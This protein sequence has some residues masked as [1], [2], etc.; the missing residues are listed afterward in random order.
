MG[1]GRAVQS[2]YCGKNKTR[3]RDGKNPKEFW[4]RQ[5]VFP[6]KILYKKRNPG[7][8]DVGVLAK[9]PCNSERKI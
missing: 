7:T 4:R 2:T 3:R 5:D 8:M 1:S 6:S 9:I